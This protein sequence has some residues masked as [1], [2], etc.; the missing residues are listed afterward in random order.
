MNCD[1][2]I[3][4]YIDKLKSGFSCIPDKKYTRIITPYRYQDNDIIEVYIQETEGTYIITDLGETLRHLY[5]QGFDVFTTQK[6]RY[7]LDAVLSNSDVE[8]E[9][10]KLIKRVSKEQIGDALFEIITTS[11]AIGDFIFTSRSF[12]PATFTEEVENFLKE[13][14]IDYDK[15]I[16]F[17]GKTKTT[18]SIDFELYDHQKIFLDALSP[19]SEAGIKTKVNATFRKWFDIDHNIKKLSLLNDYDYSWRDS[20]I[21][22]LEGVSEVVLWSKK[23]RIVEIVKGSL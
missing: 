13:K 4:E 10:G 2:F 23:E 20:D 19:I 7:L 11:M 8:F 22:L 21:L 6:R 18:Y 14:G 1:D 5:S 3:Q 17:E 12:E 9:N 16:K 15:K